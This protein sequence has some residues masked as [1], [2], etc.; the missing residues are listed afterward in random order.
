MNS[1]FALNLF[2]ALLFGIGVWM[3]V[4]NV[5][6]LFHK[7]VAKERME[8]FLGKKGQRQLIV[9]AMPDIPLAQRL[10]S[11]VLTD[12]GFFLFQKQDAGG[13]EERLRRA[14]WPYTSVGDYYGSK[15]ALAMA[16]F[17][18]GALCGV[19]F[20]L[21]P[22]F[23]A[24]LAAGLGVLG[25][26][27]PDEEVQSVIKERR[28]AIFREMAWTLD[29]IAAVMKTGEALEPT[30]N[31]LTSENYAWVSG[32]M[33]GLFIALLRDIAAG[34]SARRSDVEAM[35]N[36]L[37]AG[38]PADMPELDEFLQIVQVNLQKRQPVVEQIRALGRV[39]RDELNNRIDEV[40]QK[41]EL[42]VV[43]LTS[44]IVVPSMILVIGGAAILGFMTG[45]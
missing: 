40:A 18:I 22:V 16:F 23:I 10:L 2:F 20:R 37:R 41:S 27:R 1:S 13:V 21:N 14:G 44:G 34:L 43:M 29:R 35:L 4:T 5:P 38:L 15:V 8:S 31:R 33:G 39:M 30:L 11:P 7:G 9:S 42:K 36:N 45:F 32:G 25:L 26:F 28:E 19:L 12:V 3:L 17:G 24:V 6:G